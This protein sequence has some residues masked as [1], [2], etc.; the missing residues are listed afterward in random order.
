M[1]SP[2]FLVLLV[3]LLPVVHAQTIVLHAAHLLDIESGRLLTPGEVL[4]E[5][6]RIAQAA[7]TVPHPPG[8]EVLDLGETTLMPGLI[9]RACA[10]VFA[11]RRGRFAN[12]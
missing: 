6:E 8:A 11:S 10:P 12:G 2:P 9:R 7:A 4:V 1:R 5:G 3:G